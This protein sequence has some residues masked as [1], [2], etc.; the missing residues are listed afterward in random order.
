MDQREKVLVIGAAR[1]GVAVTSTLLKHGY[2]VILT[3]SKPLKEI[4]KA[5]PMIESAL[6]ALPEDRVEKLF[7]IQIDPSRVDEVGFVVISPGVPLTIPIVKAAYEKQIPLRSEV[8]LAYLLT[9][10][11]FVAITG[12]NGKTTTTTLV[13]ELYRHLGKKTYVVGNIGDPISNYVDEAQPNDVFV[14]EISS[15]Q[16]QSCSQ[17]HPV[18]GA[19]LNLS[20]DHLDRHKDLEDYYQTKA[21]LFK[22]FTS[23]DVMVLNAD[24]PEVCRVTEKAKGRKIWFS[25]KKE[26]DRGIFVK[27]VAIVIRDQEDFLVC[28]IDELG[29]KGPHN[30]MNA[31]AAVGLVYFAQDNDL[32]TGE[33]KVQKI[34]ETLVSFKGVA[35]RQERFAVI[36]GVTYINDSKGTNTDAAITA[37]KAMTTPVILIAG[38][39]DKHENYTA[40]ITEAKKCVKKMIL[41][42]ATA[43]DIAKCA[44]QVGF[45]DYV[46]SDDFE[47]AVKNAV[48]SAEKGDTV[49][50]SPACASWGMFNN[51]EERGDLFKSL[52]LSIGEEK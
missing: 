36:N 21:D 1:S 47:D 33:E 29:I 40:F 25:S 44:D 12:T 6:E 37:L 23:G 38:G 16:L 5:F 35:H 3:D 22:N 20:P 31:M 7:G 10:T 28:T 26:V 45:S 17:F 2:D 42:G 9:Q 13:G 51:F 15:F 11:P 14:A 27:D 8:E 39:Y 19:L 46:F 24:D 50:L 49:L 32:L 41:I 52:V 18:A 30:V 43:G 4:L 48:R 34:R